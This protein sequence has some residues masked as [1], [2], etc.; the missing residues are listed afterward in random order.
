MSF[1]VLKAK[2]KEKKTPGFAKEH[3]QKIQRERTTSM[4]FATLSECKEAGPL[5]E[6]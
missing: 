1:L 3:K 6:K 2:D 5:K 4:A